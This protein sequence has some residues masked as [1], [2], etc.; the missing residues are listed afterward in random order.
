[1]YTCTLYFHYY[2][3][4]T[5]D[6]N[7]RYFIYLIGSLLV[8]FVDSTLFLNVMNGCIVVTV[9]KVI[10]LLTFYIIQRE[11]NWSGIEWNRVELNGI[12]WN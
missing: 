1:M 4:K 7:Q 2:K 5:C 10:Y 3:I 8:T 6:N 9:I 11:W 12:E